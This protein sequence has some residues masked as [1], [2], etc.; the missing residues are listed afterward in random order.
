MVRQAIREA[1]FERL[2]LVPED[3]TVEK[4]PGVGEADEVPDRPGVSDRKREPAAVVEAVA[5][6]HLFMRI[7]FDRCLPSD[8]DAIVHPDPPDPL[9]EE[10]PQPSLPRPVA[11]PGDAAP[12][13]RHASGRP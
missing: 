8:R 2:D 12:Q 6:E 1:P 7:R 13:E 3:R 10:V 9:L 4:G 11:D 5:S